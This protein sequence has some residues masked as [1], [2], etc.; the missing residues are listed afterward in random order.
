[1][2]NDAEHHFICLFA[3]PAS[4]LVFLQ[5]F[6]P[7]SLLVF[8]D[9]RFW[10]FFIYFGYK[11]YNYKTLLRKNRTN[12]HN[13][14]SGSHFLDMTPMTQQQKKT[15]KRDLTKM[16]NIFHQNVVST[17][18]K[19]NPKK[20]EETFENH[21]SDERLISRMYRELLK[22]NNNNKN[23]NSKMSKGHE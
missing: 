22:L 3:I 18:N 12:L 15:Q 16:L 4:S 14:E 11:Y 10:V 13:L 23:P 19:G 7:F 21:I 9:V 17:E 5:I 2:S 6:R 1:M 8:L 20:C